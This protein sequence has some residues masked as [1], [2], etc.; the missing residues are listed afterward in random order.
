MIRMENSPVE[1]LSHASKVRGTLD[2]A[3]FHSDHGRV[4][5]SQAFQDHCARR[6]VRQSRGAVGTSADH[7]LAESCNAAGKRGV[8][9]LP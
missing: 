8:Y 4:Y 6:G 9:T 7:A 5:T 3:L 2:G 1:A